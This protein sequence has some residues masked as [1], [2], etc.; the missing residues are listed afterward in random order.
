MGRVDIVEIEGM[1]TVRFSPERVCERVIIY[2]HGG[3]HVT[4]P[5]IYQMR[6]CAELSQAISARILMPLYPLLP[7]HHCLNALAQL[8]P[9]CRGVLSSEDLPVSMMGDSSGGGL[10]A[11]VCEELEESLQP[12]RMVLLSP[13]VDATMESSG[14]EE[15]EPVD[16]VLSKPG[17]A[18]IGREWA[19]NLNPADARVSPINGD[20]SKLRNVALF[21]GE[22]EILRPDIVRFYHKLVKAGC[23]ADLIVGKGEYHVYPI[24]TP[25][26]ENRS[27]RQVCRAIAQNADGSERKRV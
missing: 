26:A 27:F 4:Q 6:F 25:T 2:L 8:L 22:R 13:W 18:M 11:V 19:G 14:I 10:C 1:P 5:A 9:F 17:L 15:L 12:D 21:T 24:F 7:G 16:P 23:E 20:L 3:A